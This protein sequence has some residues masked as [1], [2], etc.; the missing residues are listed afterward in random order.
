MVLYYYDL[1]LGLI[2]LA[3]GSIPALVAVFD[4]SLTLAIP[5]AAA[6]S[7]ALIG[8]GLFVR[9]PNAS[10]ESQSESQPFSSAD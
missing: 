3:M 6:V 5:L 8:H 9:P 7:V 10:P 2:S 4:V 1:I